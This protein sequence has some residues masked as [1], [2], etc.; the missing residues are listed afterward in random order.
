MIKG[1]YRPN[2]LVSASWVNLRPRRSL[3][4]AGLIVAVLGCLALLSVFVVPPATAPGWGRWAFL[5]LVVYVIA[6]FGIGIPYR[7]RRSYKQRKDLQR[8]CTFDPSESGLGFRAEN[9]QAVKP[10]SDY[11]KWKEGRSLFLIYMSDN[12]YQVIPKRFFASEGEVGAFRELVKAK[13]A[14]YEA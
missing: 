10:W 9:V 11:L 6:S 13:V 7:S 1:I 5:T 2:D 8:E 12:L 14:R 4:I 3:A